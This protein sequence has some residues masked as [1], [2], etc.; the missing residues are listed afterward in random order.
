MRS[1]IALLATYLAF[2]PIAAFAYAF[3]W[4]TVPNR[5]GLFV[6]LGTA[7][8]IIIAVGVVFWVAMPLAN[9]GITR[10]A[11]GEHSDSFGSVLGQRLVVGALI[12]VGAICFLLFLLARLFRSP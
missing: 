11:P 10:A 6:A 7:L 4:P 2:A 3:L 1:T 12:A 5:A 8:G 9:V